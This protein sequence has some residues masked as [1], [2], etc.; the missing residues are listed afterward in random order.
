MVLEVG[1]GTHSDIWSVGCTVFEMATRNPP[2][3]S[4]PPL[5]AIFS[6]GSPE[7]PVPKI[8]DKFSAHAQTFVAL[9]MQRDSKLRPSAATLL[10]HPFILGASRKNSRV[11]DNSEV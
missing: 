4:M 11:C 6:I 5:A 10:N 1:Y 8:G 7:K 3:S 9:C 2:W